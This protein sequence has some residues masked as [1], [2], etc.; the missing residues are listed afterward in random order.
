M[1]EAFSNKADNYGDDGTN[2]RAS[3]D[4]IADFYDHLLRQNLAIA[5]SSARLNVAEFRKTGRP[6]H[7]LWQTLE[8]PAHDFAD[9]VARFYQMPRVGLAELMSGPSLAL[10]DEKT[11][12]VE[13]LFSKYAGRTINSLNDMTVDAQ[14]SVYIGSMNY[15]ALDRSAKQRERHVR[16]WLDQ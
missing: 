16:V 8:M 11:G 15:N 2:P 14:G 5:D 4:S 10:W 1:R 3:L 6:L 7:K 12:K 13:E 9:Q